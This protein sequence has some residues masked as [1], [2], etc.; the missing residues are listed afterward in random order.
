M[1]Y[2][3]NICNSMKETIQE[4]GQYCFTYQTQLC[5]YPNGPQNTMK[6]TFM[7]SLHMVSSI[8]T[9]QQSPSLWASLYASHMAKNR[10]LIKAAL[11]IYCISAAILSSNDPSKVE[12][13]LLKLAIP[14]GCLLICVCPLKELMNSCIFSAK[15]GQLQSR[16]RRRYDGLNN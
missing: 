2:G 4:T 6:R 3:M 13:N 8:T 14:T 11:T 1:S 15:P 9:P 5:K 12:K 7:S 16:S 10:P